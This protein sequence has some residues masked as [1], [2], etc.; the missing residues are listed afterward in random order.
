MIYKKKKIPSGFI[1]FFINLF[2]HNFFVAHSQTRDV[3]VELTEDSIQNL[4]LASTYDLKVLAHGIKGSNNDEF[5]RLIR[6][7][8]YC[9]EFYSY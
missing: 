2:A 5:N 8:A 3:P 9:I 6:N 7:G 1:H 4:R